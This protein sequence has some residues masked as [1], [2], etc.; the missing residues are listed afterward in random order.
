MKKQLLSIAIAL[1]FVLLTIA[2]CLADTIKHPQIHVNTSQPH[3]SKP[4]GRKDIVIRDK[5]VKKRNE[6]LKRTESPTKDRNRQPGK[7]RL[8]TPDS[9]VCMIGCP[10]I[11]QCSEN[12]ENI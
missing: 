8:I 7:D 5:Y 11:C 9:E 12:M 10:I 4:I 1:F 2:P 3:L 6:K